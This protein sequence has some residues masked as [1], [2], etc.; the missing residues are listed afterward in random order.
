MQCS[1]DHIFSPGD[2]ITFTAYDLY[3]IYNISRSFEVVTRQ[4]LTDGRCG[5]LPYIVISSETRRPEQD[6]FYFPY[7]HV[8]VRPHK[9]QITEELPWFLDISTMSVRAVCDGSVTHTI[10]N[11]YLYDH[12]KKSIVTHKNRKITTHCP[13]TKCVTWFEA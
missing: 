6:F 9:P 1:K 10:G 2:R 7:Q 3:N 8:V 13:C 5:P 4:V 11:I 12:S